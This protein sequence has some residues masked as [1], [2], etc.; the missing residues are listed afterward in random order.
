MQSSNNARNEFLTA[1]AAL[2]NV[3][4]EQIP[5]LPFGEWNLYELADDCT[6]VY[7]KYGKFRVIEKKIDAAS[8][9]KPTLVVMAGYS[10]KSFCGSAQIIMDN[11]HMLVRKYKAIYIIQDPA[12]MVKLK[13]SP[14]HCTK[15][16]SINNHEWVI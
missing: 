16:Y 13:K 4:G 12:F 8:T 3:N 5:E 9:T 7:N 6:K 2:K 1:C 10:L 14:W 11:L 15:G